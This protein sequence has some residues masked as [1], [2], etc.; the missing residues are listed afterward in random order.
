MGIADTKYYHAYSDL[1]GYLWT[2]EKLKVGG[3]DVLEEIKGELSA[4]GG[5]PRYIA[6]RIE[7]KSV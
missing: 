2:T 7:R 4:A 3:H 1:T 6:L 5:S